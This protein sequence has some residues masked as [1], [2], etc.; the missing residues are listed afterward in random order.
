V[1]EKKGIVY[2]GSAINY[3]EEFLLAR[4]IRLGNLAT[5]TNPEFRLKFL[6]KKKSDSVRGMGVDCVD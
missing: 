6:D 3:D 5:S 1:H 2:F 4:E